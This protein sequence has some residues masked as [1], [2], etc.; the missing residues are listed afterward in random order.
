[1]S[2]VSQLLSH[3]VSLVIITYCSTD[4]LFHWTVSQGWTCLRAKLPEAVLDGAQT[5][6]LG[7][8]QSSLMSHWWVVQEPNPAQQ[9][10][11][12]VYQ[13]VLPS[14][15]DYSSPPHPSSGTQ[16]AQSFSSSLRVHGRMDSFLYSTL[17]I[18]F[19]YFWSTFS[20]NLL[21]LYSF[22]LSANLAQKHQGLFLILP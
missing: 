5:R 3:R 16:H 1:M 9:K 15:P 8:S 12:L 10:R 20:S 7:F 6:V 21:F 17:H 2:A 13:Q 19:F 4:F 22:K 11:K 14:W 18:F